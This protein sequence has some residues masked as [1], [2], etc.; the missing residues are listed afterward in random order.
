MSRKPPLRISIITPSLNAGRYIE[1][2]IQSVLQQGHPGVEHV[3]VDG[4]STDGTLEILK[5][6][7]HLKWVSEP[8][9]GQGEAMNKGFRLS[10]GEI[11]GYLNADDYYLPGALDAALAA[12]EHGA[13][14]VVGKI[15]VVMDD[16]SSWIND[17]RVGHLEMLRHWE[18]NA[19][20]VN[21]VGYFYRRE[22][23]ERVR[24]FNENNR[25][26][27]DLEFLL[28]ASRYYEF[29][30]IDAL[31]GVFRFMAGTV[32]GDSQRSV[33]VWTREAFSFIERFL[34]GLPEKFVREFQVSRDR[35]Y[36]QRTCPQLEEALAEAKARLAAET[37]K[38]LYV[39]LQR[40]RVVS[41]LQKRIA[42][43]KAK[44]ERA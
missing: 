4:D 22:V 41:R 29:T 37:G 35:G 2:A 5:R 10:T 15:Q 18:P 31:L 21:P 24:G 12:L 7:P 42:G 20:C 6:F 28:D 1:G 32:T 16:G 27:M 44:L 23:Q 11:I 40:R 26:A 36:L 8:D 17:P 3:V 39:R 19:F 34:E 33:G 14:F 43:M 13:A 9:R 25:L 38:N 30:K